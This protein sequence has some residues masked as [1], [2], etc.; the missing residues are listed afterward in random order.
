MLR[1]EW[2]KKDSKDSYSNSYSYASSYN[3]N[4]RRKR[5]GEASDVGFDLVWMENGREVVS[6]AHFVGEIKWVE[7]EIVGLWKSKVS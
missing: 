5:N 4:K 1:K 6:Y 2:R 7:K 3:K